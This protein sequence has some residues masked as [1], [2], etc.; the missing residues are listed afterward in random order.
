L[1]HTA[2]Q[3]RPQ[4]LYQ[5]TDHVGTPDQFADGVILYRISLPTGQ[6]RVKYVCVYDTAYISGGC[7]TLFYDY[8]CCCI[9]EMA[10]CWCDHLTHI[11]GFVLK[12]HL[13]LLLG[14]QGCPE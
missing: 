13:A 4:L 3:F 7:V 12:L 6:V 1:P 11:T 14:C 8:C 5:T 2:S 9:R 10:A